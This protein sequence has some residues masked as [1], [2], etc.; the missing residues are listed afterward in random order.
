MFLLSTAHVDSRGQA[1]PLLVREAANIDFGLRSFW[2]SLFFMFFNPLFWNIA[3]RLE[4]RTQILTK[5]ARGNSRRACL[6]LAATIFSLG[7]LRDYL[8]EDRSREGSLISCRFQQAIK[9]QPQSA[10][11]GPVL[12]DILAPAMILAGNILVFTS[13]YRLGIIGTYLG[14]YFGFLMKEPVT[15][16]PYNVCDHPMYEGATLIFLGYS[17]WYPSY[18]C[19]RSGDR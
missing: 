17:L 5:L 8:Y 16:F 9:A 4:H 15:T 3:G 10:W 6:A 1:P 13:M 7:L 12:C 14:D 18:C 2:L 11:F 19:A